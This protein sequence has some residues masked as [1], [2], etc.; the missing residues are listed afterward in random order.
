MFKIL[1]RSKLSRLAVVMLAFGYLVCGATVERANAM[2]KKKTNTGSR[3]TYEELSV[4]SN[5]LHLIQ[6]NYV[7]EVEVKDLVQGAIRGMLRTLDPHSSFMTPDMYKE[8]QIDTRGEF[9]GLGIEIGIRDGILTVI[10]PIEDT[11]AFRAGIEAGDKI[12]KISGESTKNMTLTDAVKLMRGKKGTPITITIAR[13]SFTTPKDFV[14][15]RDIIKLKSTRGKLIDDGIGYVKITS[16]QEKTTKDLHKALEKM[17]ADDGM[18]KGLILDL[19][20]NPGGLLNQAVGVSDT[21]IDS[22][23][24]VYTDGRLRSQKTQFPAKESGTYKDFPIVVLV[25]S[26][27]ASASEI[28]AGALQDHKRAIVI[29]IKTFGKGSVQTIMS[30]DDGSALRLTTAKYYTPNGRSIQAKGIVPDI[31]V[32]RILKKPAEVEAELPD[33]K[34]H[35]MREKDLDHHFENEPDKGSKEKDA[36]NADEEK[37]ENSENGEDGEEKVKKKEY[38]LNDNQLVRAIDI[39]KSLDIFKSLQANK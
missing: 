18:S 34:S 12:I 23:L 5:V 6:G 24:I 17:T 8:M 20:N 19:R 9:G 27:S 33:N 39:L 2:P 16:F 32:K 31:E 10:S 28:V 7:E 22:G 36:D 38:D 29:G 30:L 25:N 3:N 1:S 13:E 35:V 37:D 11:P 26:G 4:F 14:I 15:V 21:F